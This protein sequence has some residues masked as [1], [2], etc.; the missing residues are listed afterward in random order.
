MRERG[1][2][3]SLHSGVALLYSEGEH[4]R[5]LLANFDWH[6]HCFWTSGIRRESVPMTSRLLAVIGLTTGLLV[7][8]LA[9]LPAEA[10]Y[11]VYT[12]QAS[13]LAATG[14]TSATGP[15]PDTPTAAAAHT[16]GSITLN[17]VSPSSLNFGT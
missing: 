14:A 13:F 1:T 17:A 6:T 2:V 8:P 7:T 11:A 10:A 12:D 16:V 4:A 5:N 9:V 15:L 3:V